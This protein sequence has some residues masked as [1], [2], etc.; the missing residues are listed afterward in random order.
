MRGREINMPG[1]AV[2][3]LLCLIAT[4]MTM[5]DLNRYGNVALVLF[6]SAWLIFYVSTAMPFKLKRR[7]R[8]K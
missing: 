1:A 3:A 4:G 5:A 6:S 2:A 8:A 7:Q